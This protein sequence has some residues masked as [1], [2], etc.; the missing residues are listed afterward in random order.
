MQPLQLFAN[1]LDNKLGGMTSLT[2]SLLFKSEVVTKWS[3][4]DQMLR[5]F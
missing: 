5:L 2:S 1:N 4:T 3:G